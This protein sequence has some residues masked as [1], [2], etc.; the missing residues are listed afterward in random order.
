VT[1]IRQTINPIR[2]KLETFHVNCDN[3][4]ETD[5]NQ[6]RANTP[7]DANNVIQTHADTDGVAGAVMTRRQTALQDAAAE[8]AAADRLTD[9]PQPRQQQQRR[10]ATQQAIDELCEIDTRPRLTAQL[11]LHTDRNRTRN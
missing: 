4:Q 9:T 2:H 10:T 8:I 5:D 1:L 11:N 3:A 6:T 7:T